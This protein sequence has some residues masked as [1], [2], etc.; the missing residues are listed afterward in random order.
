M[1]SRQAYSRGMVWRNDHDRL[2]ERR[3]R[4]HQ[5]IVQKIDADPSLL[6]VPGKNIERWVRWSGYVPAVY[7][8]WR[9]LLDRPWQEIRTILLSTDETAVRLRQ[10]TPFVG[11]L[12]QAERRAI[13]EQ[14]GD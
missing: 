5:A 3:R 6:A 14:V 7:A 4:T 2:D 9:G 10:S 1:V 12:S 13:Y 11:I 8:E